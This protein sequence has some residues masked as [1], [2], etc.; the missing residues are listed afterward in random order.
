VI[1]RGHSGSLFDLSLEFGF[2]VAVWE[3]AGHVHSGP[4]LPLLVV[5]RV[6]LGRVVLISLS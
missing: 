1:S 3:F 6:D 4:K 5:R 2:E